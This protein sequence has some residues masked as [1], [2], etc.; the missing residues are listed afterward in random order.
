[1][2]D[3]KQSLTATP[4]AQPLRSY[5]SSIQG[6]QILWDTDAGKALIFSSRSKANKA[7]RAYRHSS[8]DMHSL[9]KLEISRTNPNPYAQIIA[10]T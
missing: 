9:I 4:H 7:I 6:S 2:P 5:L 3:Y 1:M 8:G 10:N